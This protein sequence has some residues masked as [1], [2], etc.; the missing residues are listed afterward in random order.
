MRLGVEI[1]RGLQSLVGR[2]GVGEPPPR[3]G[4]IALARLRLTRVVECI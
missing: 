1:E 3:A 2:S 4:W